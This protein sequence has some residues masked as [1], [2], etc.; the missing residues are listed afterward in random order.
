MKK[1]WGVIAG[2]VAAIIVVVVLELIS[3][4][5][6]PPPAVNDPSDYVEMAELLK[7]APFGSLLIVILGHFIGIFVGTV[8][9]LKIVKEKSSAFIVIGVFMLLTVMNFY[10]IKH[11]LWFVISDV[12]AVVLGGGIPYLAFKKK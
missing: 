12:A 8:I 3:H 9:T 11:P 1:L 10:L 2:L 5:I 6:Y 7:K 4:L